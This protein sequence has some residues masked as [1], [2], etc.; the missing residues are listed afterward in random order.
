MP[1]DT[2]RST[3]LRLAAFAALWVVAL[4]A[5]SAYRAD[6]RWAAKAGWMAAFAVPAVLL[7]WIAQRLA[8]YRIPWLVELFAMPLVIGALVYAAVA[9]RGLLAR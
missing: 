6:P 3:A 7:L 9:A 8:R 4:S 1:R 5:R 2:D